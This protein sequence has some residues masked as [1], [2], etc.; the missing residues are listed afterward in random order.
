[1]I[2]ATR[3]DWWDS[4]QL[5]LCRDDA[6]GLRAVI[7]IDDTTL[8][9]GLGGVRLRAYPTDCEAVTECR[10]LA[11][12]MTLKNA[13]AELPFG[14]GKSVILRPGA[15]VD[16]AAMMRRFGEFVARTAGAYLPG[17]DMG[18]SV[19][20]LATIG[21]AGAEVSCHE[22]DPAPWTAMGVGAAIR[23]AVEHLDGRSGVAG[24]RVLIQGVGHVGTALA[25]DLA[26]DGAEV[27]LADVDAERAESVAQRVGGSTVP[28]ADAIRTGC[29][30]Y[31]PCAI[32]RVATPATVDQMHCR[33][34]AGAANDVL[35]DPTAAELLAQRNITYVP[36]FL[37]NAGGV[38]HIHALRAGLSKPELRA[39]VLR[40]GD[41][42]QQFL[43]EADATG[44][45][46][47]AVAK[48]RAREV[49]AG[50][51]AAGSAQRVA[52]DRLRIGD[53]RI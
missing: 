37:A 16:R 45:L 1:M 20:D 8:G 4:E 24:V 17:V 31:A 10:R 7:A 44:R 23:A 33:I 14:G 52:A 15:D 49:L 3:T 21:S 46:P 26:G 18:T 53:V 30:V 6:V 9:P 28:A 38:I 19:E 34:I 32:A 22:E 12:T 50:A 51:R 48:E 42:V 43:E 13:L 40:I 11:A 5:V 35:A 39:A 27:V 2:E 25:C 47:L 29:D 36:D 41:R